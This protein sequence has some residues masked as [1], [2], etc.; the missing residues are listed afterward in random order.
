MVLGL[1]TGTPWLSVVILAGAVLVIE[2]ELFGFGIIEG[3]FLADAVD[4]GSGIVD[5][6]VAVAV[7]LVLENRDD[8]KEGLLVF[9]PVEVLLF[10]T[11]APSLQ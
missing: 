5:D 8:T 3:L 7:G 9:V 10:S 11:L 4:E 2:E 6:F 1:A